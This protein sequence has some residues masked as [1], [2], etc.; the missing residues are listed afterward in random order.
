MQDYLYTFLKEVVPPQA[1]CGVVLQ[2]VAAVR[3]RAA[4]IQ[5]GITATVALFSGVALI[6]ALSYAVQEFYAS[7]FYDYLSLMVSDHNVIF[8]F[9]QTFSYLL[10]ESLPSFAIAGV[11]VCAGV[12]GWSL[13]R[14]PR[15]VRYAFTPV[16][17]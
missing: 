9:W 7:G 4:R 16:G 15:N 6:S 17:A 14:I 12:F 5:I 13:S 11:L 10:L 3:R 2:H 1:L 8:S